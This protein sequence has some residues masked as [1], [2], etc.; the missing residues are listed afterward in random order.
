MSD[1]TRQE[2]VNSSNRLQIPEEKGERWRETSSSSNEAKTEMGEL[3]GPRLFY[4]AIP[5]SR[6]RR[7]R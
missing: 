1:L 4:L 5:C 2:A 6:R 3:E 7:H